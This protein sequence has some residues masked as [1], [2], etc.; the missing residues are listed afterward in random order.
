MSALHTLNVLTLT[1]LSDRS[2]SLFPTWEFNVT[3]NSYL[4]C[5]AVLGLGAGPSALPMQPSGLPLQFGSEFGAYPDL[6]FGSYR[7]YF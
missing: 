7:Y 3:A 4:S 1:N 5:G 6:I 2:M